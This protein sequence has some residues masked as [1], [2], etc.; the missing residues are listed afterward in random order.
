MPEFLELL[1]PGDALEALLK[2]IRPSLRTENVELNMALG[3]VT[4]NDIA[5]THPLPSFSR[6]SVDGF[7]VRASDTFGSSESLPTYLSI[8]GEVQM[9]TT[10]TF[11]LTTGNCAI[12]HTGGM[13]PDGADAVVMVEYTQTTKENEIEILKS[14]ANGENV[15]KEG[16]DVT[17]GEVVI[18]AGRRLRPAEIG[19]LAA[20]GITR[21]EVT[22]MPRVA[23]L[24]SGDEVVPPEVTIRPGQVRDVNSYTLQALVT[25][26][27]G[28]PVQYGI[29][30]DQLEI[31]AKTAKQALE[32]CDVVIFT[33]GSSASLRD[34]TSQV[35]NK[36]GQPGVLV[37]GVSVRPGKPTILAACSPPDSKEPKAVIGL[38]GNPVSALVIAGLFVVPVLRR[39]L[40]L[41]EQ[42]LRPSIMARLALNVPSQ[43]GREDWVP[44]RLISSDQGWVA[45]PI[46]S[47]SNLIFSH[48]RAD[49]MVKITPAATGLTAGDLVE[50]VLT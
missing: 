26:T 28:M 3:R 15:I 47:K 8:T 12:I 6:S 20:L 25:Q 32:E 30:P 11:H 13:L 39:L 40:G 21:V 41:P 27:G 22:S 42:P 46:F 34:L 19:G 31:L 23:I 18:P 45:E 44:V 35:V 4:S 7:A 33:A 5:A 38:P 1:P 9:G 16:E 48:V 14:V 43:S 36:L 29:L 50:V 37:H 17:T 10:P 2:Y 49:G 24:S